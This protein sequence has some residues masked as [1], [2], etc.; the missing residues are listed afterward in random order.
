MYSFWRFTHPIPHICSRH[1]AVILFTHMNK[2]IPFDRISETDTLIAFHHPQPS[3]PLHI[4]LIPKK[5]IAS[6][7]DLSEEDNI[8]FVDLVRTIQMIV[9]R[10]SLE[11]G[12]YRLNSSHQINE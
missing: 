12:V 4:L 9:K 1:C 7:M 5:G 3:H 8:L 2:F 10:F 6:L 11:P